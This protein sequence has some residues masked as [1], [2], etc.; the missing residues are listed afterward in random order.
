MMCDVGKFTDLNVV[1][2]FVFFCWSNNFHKI[3]Y[4]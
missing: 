2:L 1:F 3:F 4:G